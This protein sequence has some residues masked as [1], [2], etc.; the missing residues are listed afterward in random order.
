MDNNESR[1]ELLK[2]EVQNYTEDQL[3]TCIIQLEKKWRLDCVGDPWVPLTNGFKQFYSEDQLTESGLPNIG[4]VS[5][6]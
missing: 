2:S 3:L 5:R 1:L 4:A 6:F